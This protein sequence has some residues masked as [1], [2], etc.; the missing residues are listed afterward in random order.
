MIDKK[1][2]YAQSKVKEFY[3]LDATGQDMAFYRLNKYGI[4]E[5][6]R[7]IEGDVIQSQVLPGFQFRLSDLYR[8]PTPNQMV[9][10]P[11]YQ[12]F[13]MLDYQAE[14]EQAQKE[15]LAKQAALLQA[16]EERLAK[17]AALLRAEEERLAK[18]AALEQAEEERVAKQQALLREQAALQRAEEERLAKEQQ[19][20]A[21]E[22]AL[23]R[24][25]KE[26]QEKER[27]LA[28][29]KALGISLE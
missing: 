23:Q 29:L 14:K 3:I 10:D 26:R 27:L 9:K 25:E 21:K 17:Q 19:R 1:K 2:E 22:E 20:L 16:E 13:I 8:R 24:A 12:G 4:Y 28:K 7:P 15:R 18:E 6:I 5:R 11:V